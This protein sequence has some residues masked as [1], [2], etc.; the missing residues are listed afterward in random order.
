MAFYDKEGTVLK[1]FLNAVKCIKNLTELTTRS[2]SFTFVVSGLLDM[3]MC[4]AS[5]CSWSI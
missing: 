5:P 1:V 4:Q 2:T 3:R